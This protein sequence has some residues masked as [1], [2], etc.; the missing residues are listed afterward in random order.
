MTTITHIISGAHQ[1]LEVKENRIPGTA[2]GE[3][4]SAKD[5]DKT[6]KIYYHILLE[7]GDFNRQSFVM[8]GQKIILREAVDR[9]KVDR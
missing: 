8:D 3:V 6:G 5:R 2:I 9:E 7:N 1:F 4:I